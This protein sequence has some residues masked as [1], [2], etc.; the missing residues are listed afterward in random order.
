MVERQNRFLTSLGIPEEIAN[1]NVNSENANNAKAL[2]TLLNALNNNAKF[3]EENIANKLGINDGPLFDDKGNL[4]D[5]SCYPKNGLLNTNSDDVTE[6]TDK[7]SSAYFDS[8]DMTF[9]KD[10]SQGF[11]G[12]L[13]DRFLASTADDG[14]TSHNNKADFIFYRRKRHMGY[15]DDE[16]EG[17]FDRRR[18]V[19]S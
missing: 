14:Y 16:V 5:P 9:L 12:G 10:M 2:E 15:N 11:H 19:L 18:A 7:V 4:I 8:L 17:G 13:L 1:E 6:A 3:I